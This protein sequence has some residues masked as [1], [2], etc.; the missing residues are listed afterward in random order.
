MKGMNNG[1]QQSE[2]RGYGPNMTRLKWLAIGLPIVFLIVVDVIRQTVLS[3]R[4]Y[5]FPGAPGIIFT[6]I[7]VAV[8]VV[9]FSNVIFAFIS[10]LQQRIVNQNQQLAALNRIALLAAEEPELDHLIDT[11]L[12]EV[13]R[14]M[15]VD[16][17][18]ICLVDLERREHTAIGVRGFSQQL[19]DRI[20]RAKLNDDIIATEVVR[21]GKPVVYSNIFE[22]PKVA[23]AALRENVRAGIS[24]PLKSEGEVNGIL[25]IATHDEREFTD[26][27]MEFLDV[28]GGHLGLAI[29]KA[30]LFDHSQLQ[31]KELTALLAV[32]KAVTSS[33]DL[34]EVLEQSLDT[35]VEVTSVDAAEVWLMDGEDEL[36]LRL[37][38]GARRDAFLTQTRFRVGDG[39]PGVVAKDLT[40]ILVHDLPSDARFQRDQVVEAGFH[41]YCAI[42]MLSRGEFQG[43]LT[44]AGMSEESM[45]VPWELRL[46]DAISERVALAVEN[47]QLHQRVQDSAVILERERIAREMR[48]GLG[49]VLGYINA[50]TLA[51]K[52]LITDSRV[53]E[54]Y[55]ELS[56]MEGVARDLYADVRES[57]LGLRTSSQHKGGLVPELR[58]YM[59]R[60]GEMSGVEARLNVSAQSDKF[61]LAPS[62]EIQLMRI[63]QEALTNVRKH[64]D[65][66]IVSVDFR[67]NGSELKVEVVD[68][69]R[70]FDP[71]GP[72]AAGWPR[73]GLQTMRERAE[74]VGGSFD[75]ESEPDGGAKVIVSVPMGQNP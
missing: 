11:S 17:G 68:N 42:P 49:Q 62:I 38:R 56:D 5:V 24:A 36:A 9:G 29:R 4:S 34:D 10:R 7:V 58:Q 64:A 41:T 27:E 57:I 14:V 60:Y 63:L 66:S 72:K 20:Q 67:L 46:L 25:A 71:E 8:A 2:P 37:H 74:S 61:P 53:S 73:F 51:V 70:G 59:E 44:V 48:D 28:I 55:S 26:S 12:D 30:V 6:Y 69:G 33:F 47:A 75:I 16:A 1:E 45:K 22:D 18:L 52:K 40:R 35:I 43:V 31:N 32:G 19:T 21:T 50:K 15:K 65:A 3:D 54:A 39:L 23:E 13:V